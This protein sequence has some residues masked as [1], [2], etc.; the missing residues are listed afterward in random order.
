MSQEYLIV[1]PKVLSFRP[2]DRPLPSASTDGDERRSNSDVVRFLL[3]RDAG[4]VSGVQTGAQ[5]VGV[6]SIILQIDGSHQ[7]VRDGAYASSRN[8]SI[9]ALSEVAADLATRGLEHE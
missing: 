4:S 8:L 9:Q 6:I 1:P 3:R 5:R 7:Y 2:V